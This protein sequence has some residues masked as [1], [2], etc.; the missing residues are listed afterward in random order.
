MNFNITTELKMP[1]YIDY[2]VN[3]GPD[4]SHITND[5]RIFDKLWKAREFALS[6]DVDKHASR[7]WEILRARYPNDPMFPIERL[8]IVSSSVN[9]KCRLCEKAAKYKLGKESYCKNHI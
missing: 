4:I 2:F 5:A 8:E 3:Y 9:R 7:V 6:L 1:K